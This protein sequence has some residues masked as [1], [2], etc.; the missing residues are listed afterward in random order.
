VLST[1]LIERRERP[2]KDHVH[3]ELE[4][5][6]VNNS[7]ESIHELTLHVQFFERDPPPSKKRYPTKNRPL[8]FEGPLVPGQAVKWHVEARGTEFE[9]EIPVD[10]RLAP[11]GEDTAPTNRLA[12]LLDANHRPV[13]LHGAMMLAFLG[14]PRARDAALELREALRQDEGPYLDRLVWALGHVRACDIR[15][16]GVGPKR[17]VSLCVHNTTDEAKSGLGMRVRAL[18]R[19]FDPAKP[20]APPPIVI[21][22]KTLKLTGTLGAKAGARAQV[23]IDTTNA[24]RL[25]AE[26][27]EVFVD[28]YELL[29]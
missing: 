4:L 29:Y 28:R 21:E 19:E 24:D 9:V 2:H 7:D 15:A 27:F 23:V 20:V 22:E 6:V 10:D 26:A 18:D 3:L 25:D 8:Y 1:V 5:G 16:E 17:T 11:S 12:T 14:D 13:R